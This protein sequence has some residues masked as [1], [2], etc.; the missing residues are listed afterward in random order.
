MSLMQMSFSAAAMIIVVTLVRATGIHRLPKK[1][2]LILWGIVLFR[3]LIPLSLPSVFSIYTWLP[4]ARD[5]SSLIAG[6]GEISAV[7]TPIF[8]E[9]GTSV[10]RKDGAEEIPEAAEPVPRMFLREADASALLHILWAFGGIF[11][12]GFFLIAYRRGMRRFSLSKPVEDPRIHDWKCRHPLRREIQIKSSDRISVP[13]S[14]GLIRPVILLPENLDREDKKLLEYIL[15]HEYIHIRRLDI[16]SK[17]LMIGAVCLHWFNPL[18]WMMFFLF[19][20]DIE[21]S[22]D[23]E[24]I[25]RLGEGEKRAYAGSLIDME[26][27]KAAFIPIC[28]NFSKNAVEERIV[29]IMKMKKQSVIA[30]AAAVL[31]VLGLAAGF[32]TSAAKEGEKNEVQGTFS[33]EEREQIMALRLS[34]FEEM[35]IAE[36]QERVWE[37]TDTEAYADLLERF[38]RAEGLHEQRDRDETADF[39]FHIL[40]PLTAEK[41]KKRQ[42]G[43]Y[44]EATSFGDSEKAALEF[45]FAL[46]I[47]NPKALTVGEYDKTR[48][49]LM[50]ELKE[51]LR[52]RTK[53]ELADE[54][55]MRERLSSEIEKISKRYSNDKIEVSAEY[56]Y[57][58]IFP[59]AEEKSAAKEERPARK[60][61]EHK[62]GTEEDYR[63][64]LALKTSS[65]Q[66]M[67]VAD[68]NRVLLDWA[69]EDYERAERIGV[70][71]GLGDYGVSLSKEEKDFVGLTVWASGV[72]NA[73]FVRS[74]HLS[75]AEEDP[76]FQISL[77]SK[78]SY[79]N[80]EIT[81]W[82]EAGFSFSYHIRDKKNLRIRDRD[83]YIR[84]ML[85]DVEKFWKDAT[86]E[87]ILKMSKKDLEKRLRQAAENNSNENMRFH[88]I[89][90]QVHFDKIDETQGREGGFAPDERWI[91]EG[92]RGGENAFESGEEISEREKEEIFRQDRRE[93]AEVFSIYRPYGLTYDESKDRFYFQ[94]KK[95]R[96]FTDAE[97]NKGFSYKDGEVD[98]QVL[99]DRSQKITSIEEVSKEKFNERTKKWGQ[100]KQAGY[101][102]AYEEGGGDLE[103]KSLNAYTPFGVTYDRAEQ[104]WKYR[105]G[106]IYGLV[107][108]N[109]LTFMDA[110][111]AGESGVLILE[112]VRGKSGKIEALKEMSEEAFE[113]YLDQGESSLKISVDSAAVDLIFSESDRLVDLT[114]DSKYYDCKKSK[115]GREL[116]LEIKSKIGN[117]E[118]SPVKIRI[119]ERYRQSIRIDAKNASVE[120]H[121]PFAQ[122]NIAARFLNSNVDIKF[123]KSFAGSFHADVEGGNINCSSLDKYKNC[124]AD[125]RAENSLV[126]VPKE[127]KKSGNQYTYTHG[128]KKGRIQFTLKGDAVAEFE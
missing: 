3:L 59:A 36:Y 111:L 48:K 64:L 72:E 61:R 41:W 106:K 66:N 38:S 52:N 78:E 98:L 95:V 80:G 90:G 53:E 27:Q 93:K 76:R 29:A 89:E 8:H 73:E 5:A 81:A 127:F 49:A 88:I 84:V 24:V 11:C 2:F 14:Y 108:K 32:A 45:S 44:V 75:R 15:T 99:R 21:L 112:V 74:H 23:E 120:L 42:F 60:E 87:E 63:S 62:K 113:R 39:F 77:P 105:G 101:Q 17:V 122:S 10:F 114:Y 13:L 71:A 7:D 91:T 35:S 25:R 117:H 51:I 47:L 69:N 18:V 102:N 22:C 94:G 20:R 116:S 121:K 1:T 19:N 79:E 58:G 4:Q 34:G 97:V 46:D 128:T 96:H 6:P 67:S 9:V 85:R 103:D 57:R 115:K 55:L 26:V 40:E 104:V 107:D 43:G 100:R 56:F 118:A 68:F 70:E 92:N 37:I 82:A 119:P 123:P 126:E 50:K 125:I 65:Y 30:V 28:N 16:L 83:A 124:R 31:L 33:D 86:M 110:S 12:G 109:V 54:L